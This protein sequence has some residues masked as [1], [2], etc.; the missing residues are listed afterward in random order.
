MQYCIDHWFVKNKIHIRCK[1]LNHENISNGQTIGFLTAEKVSISNTNRF[2]SS[3]KVSR[4]HA[5]RVLTI[6]NGFVS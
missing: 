6:E 4:K 5:N 1:V 2:L 3:E